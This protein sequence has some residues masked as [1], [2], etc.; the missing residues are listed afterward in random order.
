MGLVSDIETDGSLADLNQEEIDS[1]IE[2]YKKYI[3][4]KAKALNLQ[5]SSSEELEKEYKKLRFTEDVINGRAQVIQDNPGAKLNR[6]E[7][8]AAKKLAN[9]KLSKKGAKK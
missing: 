2:V 5:V 9:N 6:A 8:R 3:D 7:R 1:L 4:A